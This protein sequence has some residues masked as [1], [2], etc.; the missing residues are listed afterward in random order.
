VLFLGLHAL[1][2]VVSFLWVFAH[3]LCVLILGFYA[4]NP[5]VIV[6]LYF[7]LSCMWILVG[8]ILFLKQKKQPYSLMPI[9]RLHKFR[10]FDRVL[11]R[12]GI[13]RGDVDTSVYY[14]EAAFFALLE[15]TQVTHEDFEEALSWE[16]QEQITREDRQR[17][18]TKKY[19]RNIPPLARQWKY[20][21]TVHV[22]RF[23]YDMVRAS[24]SVVNTQTICAHATE[25]EK[26]MLTLQRPSQNCG[27]LVGQPGV[28]RDSLVRFFADQIRK[29][30]V[31]R[32]LHDA[33]LMHLDIDQVL[34]HQRV[35]FEV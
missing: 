19:L 17:F 7:A 13:L 29:R 9:K 35:I 22:D 26:L 30:K 18:W 2:I 32:V 14:D 10:W 28:G 24:N 12:I 20:A 33:R 25:F 15:K 16:M 23:A 21:Y 27:L 11:A 6:F 8:F 3:V 5:E 1:G 34:I 4:V 31:P